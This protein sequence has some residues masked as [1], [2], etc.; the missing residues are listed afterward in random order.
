MS[1]ISQSSLLGS[2]TA[3]ASSGARNRFSD[4]SSEEFV[5]I[6]FTELTNQD[7]L[8]PNDSNQLLEQMS[9]L[10]S[11]QSNIDLQDKLSQVVTQS[12][13]AT[14][15]GLLGRE[16]SGIT[17]DGQTVRGIVRSVSQTKDGPVLNLP[18]GV[19]LPFGRVDAILATPTQTTPVAGE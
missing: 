15:G 9:N 2:T 7:P 6:M 12:Q 11:I 4:L 8:K 10:R 1:Q 5:K 18:A 19:R 3:G 16:V 13:L 14:A 17:E